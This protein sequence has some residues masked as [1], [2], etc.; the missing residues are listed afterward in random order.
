MLCQLKPSTNS[1]QVLSAFH[2]AKNGPTLQ[3]SLN[4][5]TEIKNKYVEKMHLLLIQ[6]GAAGFCQTDFTSRP[7]QA[8]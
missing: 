7:Q 1:G 4:L 6:H 5:G 2:V 8:Y 3:R